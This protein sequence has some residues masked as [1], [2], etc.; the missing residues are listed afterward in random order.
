MCSTFTL[1]NLHA[2]AAY[3]LR[4]PGGVGP[5]HL[6]NVECRGGERRL[7]DCPGNEIGDHNCDHS[8]DAAVVCIEVQRENGS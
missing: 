4:Y 8:E 5:I 1:L 6:D 2:S 7:I 3:V